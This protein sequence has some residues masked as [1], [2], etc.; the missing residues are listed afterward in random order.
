[1]LTKKCFL[2]V[3]KIPWQINAGESYNSYQQVVSVFLF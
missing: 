2:F 1:M 3:I